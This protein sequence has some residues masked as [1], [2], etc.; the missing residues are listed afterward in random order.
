ML[1][2]VIAYLLASAFSTLSVASH[3]DDMGVGVQVST[4]TRMIGQDWLGMW[5]IF[6]PVI[7]IGM[8][9][10]LPIAGWLSRRKPDLRSGWFA[11]GGATALFVVHLALELSFDIVPVAGA[12]SALGLGSQALAGGIGGLAAAMLSNPDRVRTRDTQA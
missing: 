10:A 9:I 4:L 7:A 3:L 5:A 11:L 2:V 8:A 6:L 1:A 12:R